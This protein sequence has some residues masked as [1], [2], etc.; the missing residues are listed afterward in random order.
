[1]TVCERRLPVTGP[2]VP[3]IGGVPDVPTIGGVGGAL[4]L[5]G[6]LLLL[7]V[8]RSRPTVSVDD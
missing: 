2:D 6:G 7:A 5:T 8:R 1:M 4:L 3:T